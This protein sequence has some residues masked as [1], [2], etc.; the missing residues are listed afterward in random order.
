MKK[1]QKKILTI[2]DGEKA[3]KV[4]VSTMVY[5]FLILVFFMIGL[6]SVLAY[7][8]DT[9]I[10]QKIAA[11]ISIVIPFPAAIVDWRHPVY[12]KDL[13]SNMNSVERFYRMQNFSQEGLRVDFTTEI[14]KKRLKIKQREVLDKMIEDRAIEILAKKRGIKISQVDV[15]KKVAQKLNEFGTA[16]Q[17]KEDLMKSYGWDMEDFKIKIVLPSMY[18]EALAESVF[19]ENALLNKQAEDKIKQ[20]QLALNAGKEFSE[21]VRSHSEGFSKE[22]NGELGWV[23]KDQVLVELQEALFSG[24]VS[25]KN[26]VIESSVGFHIVDVEERKKTE[27]EETVK[28]RQIFV[29]KKTFADWL[30]REKKDLDVVLPM[31]EFQW[32]SLGATVEFT[33]EEMRSFEK[34]QR[35]NAQGDASLLL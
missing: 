18:S 27:E 15:D 20:A 11:K 33:E 10:G 12:L 26:S 9:E 5:A 7:G 16:D 35:E 24:K 32:N 30:E 31:K 28:I 14:G 34:L 23:N 17:V 13:Q 19:S 25:E 3:I 22:K 4:S 21:V 1:K 29:A 2:K 8:T 6:G